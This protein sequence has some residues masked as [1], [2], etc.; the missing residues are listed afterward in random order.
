MAQLT[1][2]TSM[3]SAVR[4]LPYGAIPDNGIAHRF[5]ARAET[6]T[7]TITY[8]AAQTHTLQIQGIQYNGGAQK[9]VTIGPVTGD[10]DSATTAA[11][12]LTAINANATAKSIVSVTRSSNVLT[13]VARRTGPLV[14]TGSATGGGATTV[15]KT[16]SE[17]QLEAGV[18]VVQDLG[19]G[20]EAIRKPFTPTQQVNDIAINAVNT[21]LYTF[22]LRV[23]RPDG[24]VDGTWLLEITSD[25]SA[26]AA[27]IADAFVTRA[28]AI[29]VQNVT[30]TNSS[31]NVRITAANGYTFSILEATANLTPSAVTASVTPVFAGI[32]INPKTVDA[33]QSLTGDNVWPARN[34]VHIMRRG[35]VYVYVDQAVTPASEPHFRCVTSGS[36]TV[37]GAFRA[38]S[39]SGNALPV[40][41]GAARFLNSASAGGLAIL[42]MNLP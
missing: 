33:Q 3:P 25:G 7:A 34:A 16:V 41:R 24:T 22:T 1:I 8:S 10:T 30:L 6:F 27:E 15:A 18:A 32:P 31:N 21:T 9:S 42:E 2:N 14:I 35:M 4:G 13:L 28:S 23:F 38:D 26:T 17:E 5:N 40:P 39:D 12:I 36:N 19:N 11:A 20:D 37:L 29:G